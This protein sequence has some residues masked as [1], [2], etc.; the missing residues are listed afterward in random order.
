MKFNRELNLKDVKTSCFLFGPRLTGKTT[1]LRQLETANYFDLLSPE[2]ELEYKSNPGLFWQQ[3]S[4]LPENSI[5]IIDEIQKIPMLLDYVQ[6]GIEKH[7]F[8]FLLSGSSARKLKRGGANLLGGRAVELKLHTL[9]CKETGSLFSIDTAMEYGTLP[10]IYSLIAQN[11]LELAKKHLKSYVSTYI[12]E[13]IQ[14]E[15]LTRNV[16]AFNRFL[17][18]AAQTNGEVLEFANISRE[19]A[20]AQ[21]T[22]KEYYSILEDTLIGSYLWPYDSSERKKA[23]PKFYFFDCGV[24]RAVQNR[25]NDPPTPAE[26]GHLFETWFINELKRIND[27]SD[28]G[29]QFSFWRFKDHEIDLI[30][31]NGN[32]PVLAVECKSGIN[33]LRQPTLAQFKKKFPEVKLIVASLGDTRPRQT[34]AGV[35]IMP[36]RDVIEFYRNFK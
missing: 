24:V 30:V 35:E 26:K 31:S 27:Y 8:I 2:T 34:E 6:M 23:R 11:E 3:V 10:K 18:I 1:I 21:S 32:K 14:A 29:H 25:L 20:V 28:K 9:T 16:G 7:N 5:I 22:V 36:F 15:A 19:C 13:E 33:D 4:A 12:K 17:N